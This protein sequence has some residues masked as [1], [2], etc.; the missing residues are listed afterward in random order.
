[1][2]VPMYRSAAIPLS[3]LVAALALAGCDPLTAPAR[4]AGPGGND[5]AADDAT[6]NGPDG[7]V[8][9]ALCGNG[10]RD[11]GEPCDDGNNNS[12][13][14]C[15]AVCQDETLFCNPAKLG[16]TYPMG[17]DG[18]RMVAEGNYLYVA[19]DPGIINPIFR[20]LDVTNPEVGIG[21]A[22]FFQHDMASNPNA[23]VGDLVKRGN[24]IWLVGSDPGLTSIDVSDPTNAF[25]GS[26]TFPGTDGFAARAGADHIVVARQQSDSGGNIYNISGD[27]ADLKG[28]IGSTIHYNVGA[29]STLMFGSDFSNRIEIF[30]PAANPES[31]N[32]VGNYLHTIPW[33]STTGVRD[34]VSD[35]PVLAFST[36]GATGGAGVHV[37]DV[38]IPSAP[39]FRNTIQ[40]TPNDIAIVGKYLFVPNGGVHVYDLSD[41]ASPVLA[42]SYIESGVSFDNIAV[43]GDRV[44]ASEGQD[45]VVITGL[46]GTCN[47]ICGNNQREYPEACDDGNRDDGDG[48]NAD[49]SQN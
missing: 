18:G 19:P 31:A 32:I 2:L 27:M 9:P 44:Y 12:G 39:Q 30:S 42:G 28:N 29:S 38:G 22:S 33:D 21:S 6:A 20:I 11:T 48:C 16:N 43:D 41:S 26:I 14:G 3:L 46:P 49:C 17:S 7:A 35:G 23:K 1:M 34:I 8:D 24:R 13:D 4:D 45:L 5:G 25:L 47:A 36:V 15:S 37:I 40:G 10:N